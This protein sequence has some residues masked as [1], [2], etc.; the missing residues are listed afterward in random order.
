[1]FDHFAVIV[2]PEEA[3]RTCHSTSYKFHILKMEKYQIPYES[4]HEIF[5][6]SQNHICYIFLLIFLKLFIIEKIYGDFI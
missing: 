2:E 6:L 5:F 4:T 1:M 3:E